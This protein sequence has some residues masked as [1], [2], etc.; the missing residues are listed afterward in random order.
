MSRCVEE[1]RHER[2][3]MQTIA[4][5]A[6]GLVAASDRLLSGNTMDYR[7][8]APEVRSQARSLRRGPRPRRL[9]SQIM[10]A[11]PCTSPNHRRS[12]FS[13]Q[14]FLFFPKLF[15]SNNADD[16]GRSEPCL[17]QSRQAESHRSRAGREASHLPQSTGN[18]SNAVAATF[19]SSARRCMLPATDPSVFEAA[20]RGCQSWPAKALPAALFLLE[21]ALIVS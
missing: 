19:S 8:W 15:N 4:L 13:P 6:G 16:F 9:R 11:G 14:S 2:C 10:A 3:R 18:G 21:A 1:S 7:T 12:S 17:G 20:K 5:P